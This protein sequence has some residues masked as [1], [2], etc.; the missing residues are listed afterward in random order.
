MS[1]PLLKC[2]YTDFVATASQYSKPEYFQS[3]SA[4]LNKLEESFSKAN[5]HFNV[6]FFLD[7]TQKKYL[8]IGDGCSKLLG[9]HRDYFLKGGLEAFLSRWDKNDF[10]VYNEQI[11]PDL[12]NVLSQ[13]PECPLRTILCSRNYRFKRGDGEII[14]LLQQSYFIPDP[15]G[16]VFI[17][18]YGTVMDI[19]HFANPSKIIQTVEKIGEPAFPKKL[20]SKEM[21]SSSD[22]DFE[23]CKKELQVLRLLGDGLTSKQVAYHMKLSVHTVNT[24]RKNML[25]KTNCKSS[26]ELINVAV[27]QGLL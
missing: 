7:L 19:S 13:H 23:I 17:A 8:H 25:F 2:R 20:L 21:Y 15:T 5:D 6:S 18:S 14:T 12:L 3:S 9:F 10:K 26:A 4:V 22:K 27:N 24:H 16:T 11:F 1:S